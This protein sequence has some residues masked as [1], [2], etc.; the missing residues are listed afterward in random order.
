MAERSMDER[1]RD[2]TNIE[3]FVQMMNKSLETISEDK[4]K[5]D[6]DVQM[7]LAFVGQLQNGVK[8]T[9][10]AL[11]DAEDRIEGLRTQVRGSTV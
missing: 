1:M 9:L 11:R 8:R 3:V 2:T 7:L 4:R 10:A 5:N 6:K